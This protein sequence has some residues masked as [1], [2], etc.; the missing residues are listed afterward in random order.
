M[1]MTR[2]EHV[3]ISYT[4]HNSVKLKHI[5]WCTM[6]SSGYASGGVTRIITIF[7]V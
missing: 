5:I 6:W 3:Y 2:A 1:V 4:Y 7:V